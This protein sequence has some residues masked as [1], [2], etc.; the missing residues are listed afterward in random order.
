VVAE[1]EAKQMRERAVMAL[2]AA[3]RA[4]SCARQSGAAR[5]GQMPLRC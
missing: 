4:G 5:T 3:S 1:E 2:L